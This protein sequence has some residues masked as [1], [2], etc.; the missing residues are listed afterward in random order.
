[1]NDAPALINKFVHDLATGTWLGVL[2]LLFSLERR[3]SL[4]APAV[5]TAL[6]ALGR[7][8]YWLG[9][10]SFAVIFATGLYYMYRFFFQGDCP[11]E[12][13]TPWKMRIL[14]IKHI[15]L[16]LGFLAGTVVEYLLAFR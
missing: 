4:A 1:M 8:L 9:L 5:Q 12:A 7:D 15:L 2:F 6:A 13:D 10:F 11:P 16:T 3:S 14:V